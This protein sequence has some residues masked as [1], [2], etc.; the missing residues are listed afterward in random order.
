MTLFNPKPKTYRNEAYLKWIRGRACIVCGHNPPNDPHHTKRGGMALKG[1][2]TETVPLCRQHHDMVESVGRESFQ[3]IWNI[4]F[5]RE[6]IRCL[7]EYIEEKEPMDPYAE[8][9]R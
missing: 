7:S 6:I 9:R 8:Y 3:R 2:D 5:N 4:D 1:P